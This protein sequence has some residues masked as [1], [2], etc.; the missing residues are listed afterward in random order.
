MAY[1]LARWALRGDPVD[2]NIIDMNAEDPDLWEGIFELMNDYNDLEVY[3]GPIRTV[4]GMTRAVEEFCRGADRESAAA[5]IDRLLVYTA[6]L[7]KESS[8]M[9]R[10]LEELRNRNTSTVRNAELGDE[11]RLLP[12]DAEA[13]KSKMLEIWGPRSQEG[14]SKFYGGT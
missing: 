7:E 1:H 13:L 2:C 14:S 4:Y 3:S 10:E 6:K 8:E 11:N 12:D 5:E 9:A